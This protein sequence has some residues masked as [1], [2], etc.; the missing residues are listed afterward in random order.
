MP[1]GLT[2]NELFPELRRL[3]AA[4]TIVGFDLVEYQPFYDN[5]GQQTARLCRRVLLQFLTGIAMR[6]KGLDPEYVNPLISGDP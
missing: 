2:P 4:K 3:A 5:R 1:T 6:K